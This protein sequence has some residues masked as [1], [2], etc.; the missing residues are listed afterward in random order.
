[1][2]QAALLSIS[3]FAELALLSTKALRLYDERG[4]LR[5]AVVDPFSG[6]RFYQPEQA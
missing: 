5:P 6:Y 4:L 1:M 2:N 3:Q